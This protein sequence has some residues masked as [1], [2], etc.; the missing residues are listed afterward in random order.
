MK[1]NPNIDQTPV[2]AVY[3]LTKDIKTAE[4]LFID[5]NQAENYFENQISQMKQA[6]RSC[7]VRMDNRSSGYLVKEMPLKVPSVLYELER[8]N[9]TYG[10]R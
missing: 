4:R 1:P 10:G 6:M 7:V 3:V 2:Y 9:R 5:F 8:F